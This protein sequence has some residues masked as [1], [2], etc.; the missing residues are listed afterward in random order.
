LSEQHQSILLKFLTRKIPHPI[1]D[2]DDQQVMSSHTDIQQSYETVESLLGGIQGLS[3]DTRH[4]TSESFCCQ[5][6]LQSLS[7]DLSNVKIAIQETHSAI[8]AHKSNQQ[9]LE[10][11][12]ASFQEQINDLMNTSYD[13]T[14]I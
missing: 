2:I 12:L 10:Q 11:N 14:L 3:D 7:E 4:L 9:I 6:T 1:N 13:D 8:D 5:N